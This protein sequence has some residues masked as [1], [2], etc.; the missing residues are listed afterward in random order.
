MQTAQAPRRATL[1]DLDRE[2]LPYVVLVNPDRTRGAAYNSRNALIVQ[3]VS[4]AL[5]HFAITRHTQAWPWEPGLSSG[6]HERPSWMPRGDLT[7]WH[8]LWVRD[9]FS[10]DEDIAELPKR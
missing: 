5:L 4:R 10:T 7:G 9:E 6:P 8:S 3:E 2:L 1:T